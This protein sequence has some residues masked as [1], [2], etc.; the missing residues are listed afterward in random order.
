MKSALVALF[1]S[2][3]ISSSTESS[4]K[5]VYTDTKICSAFHH[6][7]CL[8]YATKKKHLMLSR[9]HHME[10]Q[11]EPVED[12]LAAVRIFA[13][14]GDQKLCLIPKIEKDLNYMTIDL[15]ECG[16]SETELVLS[17]EEKHEDKFVLKLSEG[18]AKS[19]ESKNYCLSA[20]YRNKI[21]SKKSSIHS[22]G[23]VALAECEESSSAQTLEALSYSSKQVTAA[24]VSENSDEARFGRYCLEARPDLCLGVSL[25]N[26]TILE[27][28]KLIQVKN[29]TKN[30]RNGFYDL[31]MQWYRDVENGRLANA[32]D[33]DYCLKADYNATLGLNR[34]GQMF[35]DDTLLLA[36][37]ST[38]EDEKFVF[39]QPS[40]EREF[41][42]IKSEQ[43]NV[44][45]TVVRC[46]K[47]EENSFCSQYN[48]FD[49]KSEE[50]LEQGAYV[51]LKTCDSEANIAQRWLF[52]PDYL[53]TNPPTPATTEA[54]TG[55]VYE[56][57]FPTAAPVE[58][59]DAPTGA[60]TEVSPLTEQP[61]KFPTL[62][63]TEESGST[64]EETT[65]GIKGE[66]TSVGLTV[67]L[68][69]VGVMCMAVI[70]FGALFYK[71]RQEEEESLK[72]QIDA[73]EDEESGSTS[74]N[75]AEEEVVSEA[76]VPQEDFAS[77][78][79]SAAGH[80]DNESF[81]ARV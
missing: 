10:F 21:A 19:E 50:D 29:V 49:V 40:A 14:K 11:V 77:P 28:D 27:A 51:R 73:D 30:S 57:D 34:L 3:G 53:A 75:D 76:E 45:A 48:S 72:S 80:E 32:A 25:T 36:Q 38:H 47:Y 71:R 54:P 1:A 64:G 67:G 33:L 5:F 78:T 4:A 9:S 62:K 46:I 8:S 35:S 55:T 26:G 39:N 31:K 44:C 22:G 70:V 65:V 42:E 61:T 2:F 68:I 20:T 60:P 74:G 23:Y 13:E 58:P 17:V 7:L 52:T 18:V 12:Y 43:D 6:S 63:P 66:E 81:I 16:A 59:T 69:L 56:T 37:C 24:L 15:A 41:V 79:G